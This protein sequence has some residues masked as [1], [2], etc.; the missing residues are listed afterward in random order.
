MTKKSYVIALTSV[1]VGKNLFYEEGQIVGI[2]HLD[3]YAAVQK[4]RE[5]NKKVSNYGP[6]HFAAVQ[7]EDTLKKGDVRP[8]L[9]EQWR[10]DDFERRATNVMIGVLE[11]E[12]TGT[13][14]HSDDYITGS[15]IELKLSLA[16]LYEGYE[17]RARATM[18]ETLR[19]QQQN[20][21]RAARRQATHAE[22]NKVRSEITY[23]FPA[24]R[25]IQATREF[26]VAQ[27][28]FGILTRLFVFD[29]EEMIPAEHRAQRVLNARRAQDIGNYVVANPEDY[30]LPALTAS[31][32]AEMAFEPV[33]LPGASDRVGT[34]HIPM[35][36][37]ML[38]NDGQHRR[39]GIELAMA[40]RPALKQE[41]I[42]VTIYYDR[43]LA[44]S[45]QMFADINARQV[46]PSSAISALYD[47][48]NPFNA[49]VLSIL[50]GLPEIKSR[51]DFENPSPGAK[52]HKLWSIVVFK[53]FVTLLTS[54]T[55]KNFAEYSEG[56]LELLRAIIERFFF[57]CKRHIPQWASMIEGNISASEVR[58][59][60]VIGH[61]VWLEAL[62][63]FGRHLLTGASDV[64]SVSWLRM[65]S[66][67]QI[68]P[69]K[70]SSMWD[71]RCVV[72]GKMQ[73]TSDGVNSSAAQL[74]KIAKFNLSPEMETLDRRLE[75]ALC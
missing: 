31:V 63:V 15:L 6:A 70:S 13:L 30:I 25:G 55:E 58:D 12:V 23:S 57:E 68:S 9:V 2:H 5:L 67:S 19:I 24:V 10:H 60:F 3:D 62:G 52:S 44:R 29:E 75:A 27:I 14:A 39:K 56:K 61:A 16:E 48:R 36:A 65:Q 32:S 53:K 42:A 1:S 8:A 20:A 22:L 73:K 17:D 46:K 38:I 35:D 59:I 21:E 72:L 45:Q 66:L 7:S 26:Y 43:G 47:H 49:W 11:T 50:N 69:L 51:I 40:Q 41:T 18:A 4:A 71:G 37:V 54:C 28:P 33:V 74:M 64:G 34:L